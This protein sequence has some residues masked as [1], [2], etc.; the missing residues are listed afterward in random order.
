MLG[1]L[2]NFVTFVSFV[3]SKSYCVDTGFYEAF[4][5]WGDKKSSNFN[6]FGGLNIFALLSGF[7]KHCPVYDVIVSVY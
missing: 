1:G 2:P 6:I 7:R 3:F 5:N 4:P